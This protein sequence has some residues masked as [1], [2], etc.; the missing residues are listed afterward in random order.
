MHW[1][2]TF[3]SVDLASSKEEVQ[4]L[5][6][7]NLSVILNLFF[8]NELQ[9]LFEMERHE[10][11]I[12]PGNSLLIACCM[13]KV[14]VQSTQSIGSCVKCF[15]NILQFY[16]NQFLINAACVGTF[17]SSAVGLLIKLN[18]RRSGKQRIW[19]YYRTDGSLL[20]R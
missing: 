15:L 3:L 19:L 6:T 5:S 17:A 20:R 2:R 18:M 1:E 4:G 10:Q 11:L 7:E 8:Y 9:L 13:I 14:L 16:H 12:Q